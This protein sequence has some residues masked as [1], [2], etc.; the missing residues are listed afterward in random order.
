MPPI[1]DPL[2]SSNVQALREG[3]RALLRPLVFDDARDVA[4]RV[5]AKQIR[6][7][8]GA[9]APRPA[10]KALGPHPG[11]PP[12]HAAQL[13]ACLLKG[14]NDVS[15]RLRPGGLYHPARI[16]RPSPGHETSKARAKHVPLF[17][18]VKLLRSSRYSNSTSNF[19]FFCFRCRHPRAARLDE[20]VDSLL[21]R[22]SAA[23]ES[24]AE[25]IDSDGKVIQGKVRGDLSLTSC[26]NKRFLSFLFQSEVHINL[27]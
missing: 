7:L 10:E 21:R 5:P 16:I 3:L 9:L 2:R 23:G 19:I 26:Q 20:E 17:Y 14:G 12:S 4:P 1:V 13:R 27:A 6:A 8:P 18:D 15:V 11:P 25:N 22:C 24:Y